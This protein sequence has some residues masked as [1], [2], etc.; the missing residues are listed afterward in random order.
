[1]K[2]KWKKSLAFILAISLVLSSG[3]FYSDRYLKATDGETDVVEETVDANIETTVEENGEASAELSIAEAAEEQPAGEVEEVAETPAE[4]PAAEAPAEEPAAEAPAEEPAAE[5]PAEEPAAEA[6][7]EEPAAETPA[8]EAV[9][10][11]PAAEEPVTAE[12][13]A[14]ADDATAETPAEET[15]VSEET[16]E[17]VEAETEEA[18]EEETETEE[19]EDMPAATVTV[20][21]DDGV[22]ITVSAPEGAL[23]KGFTVKAVAVNPAALESAIV[24]QLEAAGIDLLSF[25]AYDVTIYDKKGKE[26]QPDDSVVVTI[27]NAPTEGDYQATFHIDD[28]GNIDNIS[29]TTGGDATITTD[30]FSI[31]GALSGAKSSTDPAITGPTEVNVGETIQLSVVNV[32]DSWKYYSNPWESSKTSI[33]KVDKNGVVTGV[34]EGTVTI[35][36]TYRTGITSFSDETIPYTVTVKDTKVTITGA[37]SVVAGKTITLSADV[38]GGTWSVDSG[39]QYA[40][41]DSQTGVVT[42]IK[43]GNARIKYTVKVNNKNYTATHAVKV[44]AFNVTISGD[45]SVDVGNTIELTADEKGGTWS[46]QSGA[47]KASVDEESGIVTGLKEGSATIKYAVELNGVTFTATYDITVTKARTIVFKYYK[48]NPNDSVAVSDMNAVKFCVLLVDEDGTQTY[49][50]G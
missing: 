14:K 35:Y 23:P 41:V 38:P 8:E 10:E 16:A 29:E 49:Y 25:V 6:P 48:G 45:K 50:N 19:D 47:D 20:K 5:S 18:T 32:K 15:T 31:V 7:A 46:V 13:E 34:K 37:D 22:E 30:H 12:A 26:I 21:A 28:A 36:Y 9:A 27:G 33:A 2:A 4:E 1:M 43:A 39:S 3:V 44:N 42:G 40:S 17:T 24:S 11:T